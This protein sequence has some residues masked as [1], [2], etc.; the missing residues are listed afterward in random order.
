MVYLTIA[1]NTNFTKKV[2]NPNPAKKP[3][4]N[5]QS[6]EKNFWLAIIAS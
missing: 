5:K 3:Y 1:R 2:R 4:F 6:K